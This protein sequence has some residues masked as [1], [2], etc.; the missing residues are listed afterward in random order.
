MMLL[1]VLDIIGYGIHMT[2]ADAE[3]TI[4]IL[5]T[6]RI[7]F[8]IFLVDP[9]ATVRLDYANG[10]TQRHSLV[11]HVQDVDVVSRTSHTYCG[12]LVVVQYTSNISMH[13]CKVLL[14]QCLGSSLGGE[15]QMNVLFR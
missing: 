12:T 15:N 10:L 1:L 5:P 14:G 13:L 3:C 2:L 7:K 4:S 9:F 11:L 6:K 8:A